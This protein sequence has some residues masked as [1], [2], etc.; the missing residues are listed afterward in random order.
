MHGADVDALV[1][2][3]LGIVGGGAQRLAQIGPRQQQVDGQ[4][5]H[6]G[7]GAGVG[8]RL[9]HQHGTDGER[10]GGVGGLDAARGGREDHGDRVGDHEGEPEGQDELGVHL[11]LGIALAR[12]VHEQ[13]AMNEEAE[14]EERG[15]GDEGAQEGIDPVAHR[16]PVGEVHPQHHEVALGEVDHAHDAEDQGE[17]DAHEGVDAPHEQ[18]GHHVLDQLG[19]GYGTRGRRG[20]PGGAVPRERPRGDVGRDH[21]ERLAVLPLHDDRGGP[22]APSP[23][24]ILDLAGIERRRGGA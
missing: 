8:A 9:V 6:D 16:E 11:A 14:E 19:D 23:L 21:R 13:D 15:D 22:E 17:A 18:A 12:H 2:G 10:L 3:R 5:E 7:H 1:L 24:V 20:L 4:G